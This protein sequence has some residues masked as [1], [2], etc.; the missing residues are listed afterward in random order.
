MTLPGVPPARNEEWAS[1]H[2]DF[3]YKLIEACGNPVLLGTCARLSDA[4][5]LYRTW[6]VLGGE[7][8]RDVAGEH[9]ALLE[10][11]LVHEADRAVTMFEAHIERTQALVIDSI[12][13]PERRPDQGA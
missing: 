8:H 6:S 11:A 7:R 3:H 5:E 4:A 2:L 12:D 1:A 9:R 13:D 10:A